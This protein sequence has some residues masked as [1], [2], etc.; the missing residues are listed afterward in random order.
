M[1]K[2]LLMH[3]I[4]KHY[5][6]PELAFQ[7]FDFTGTGYVTAD[8]IY[9]HTLVFRLPFSKAELK[10]YLLHESI[11]QR[12][13]KLTMEVFTKHF[14]PD[15]AEGYT[16]KKKR[17]DSKGGNDSEVSEEQ[18]QEMLA[19]NLPA[20]ISDLENS[21]LAGG[22]VST[23]F[24]GT[25]AI[26][27]SQS[28]NQKNQI[29]KLKM[30]QMENVLQNRLNKKFGNVR[31]AFLELD[32]DQDGYIT[33]DDLAKFL[34]NA[35]ST[36]DQEGSGKG[37]NFTLL[38]LL[39]K[40]R[41][42][43]K[44]TRINYTKFCS[45]LGTSIEPV[46]AFYFRHDSLK[47]PQFDLN[48]Q[49]TVEPKMK[50][51]KQL[52][53][54][55]TGNA[56]NLKELFIR[57]V[58]LQYKTLKKAFY[59]LDRYKQGHVTFDKFQEILTSWGF[60]AK[61][62]QQKSLFNWLDYD[63]DQKI[64]FLDLRSSIGLEIL[65]MESFFFRQDVKH[66]KKATCIYEDCWENNSFNQSSQYCQ[67]HQKIIKNYIQDLLVKISQKMSSETWSKFTKELAESRNIVSLK[68]LA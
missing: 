67:L 2:F 63:K 37:F 1:V 3:A 65:P 40:I 26:N 4:N 36:E 9:N 21:K 14:Y 33:A 48:M 19:R 8:M 42:K 64:S 5:R 20:D 50:T 45:W 61:E 6:Y 16:K 18:T 57:K 15:M 60:E 54:A 47:N 22:T 38:E 30:A 56:S 44:E 41:C 7:T 23:P 59:E 49:K 43:L 10:E 13:P 62:S 17:N 46:E 53:E 34:K 52:R 35:S 55:L 58:T 39:I 28:L 12:E 27:S 24:L 31:K 25:D 51:Q 32:Q 68:R 66:G 11:F 29:F